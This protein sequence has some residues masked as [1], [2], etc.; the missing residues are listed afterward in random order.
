M[1]CVWVWI[2]PNNFHPK[3]RQ[4][5]FCL[6][7]IKF[8]ECCEQ[9]SGVGERRLQRGRGSVQGHSYMGNA[10][11]VFSFQESGWDSHVSNANDVSSFQ[12]SGWAMSATQMKCSV[13]KR[14]GGIAMSATQMKCS[15]FHVSKANEVFSFQESGW[16]SHVSSAND[17]SSFQE[18]GW[19]SH[20]SSANEVFSFQESGWDSH[21]SNANEVFSF[22]ES[23]WDSH[24]SNA[25]EVFSFQESGWDSHVSNANEVFSFQESGWDSH[26]SNANE[27]FSFQESGWDSHVSNMKLLFL[28]R[29][30]NH[31]ANKKEVYGV[32]GENFLMQTL[33]A[34][35]NAQTH[36]RYMNCQGVTISQR[37]VTQASNT[38]KASIS[39][40][41][42]YRSLNVK[43]EQIRKWLTFTNPPNPS[44]AKSCILHSSVWHT[45]M[46]TTLHPGFA[47]HHSSTGYATKGALL[48][49]VNPSLFL[50]TLP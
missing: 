49:S 46:F 12:E 9:R 2:V 50:Q 48:I 3:S 41:N 42:D 29:E 38:R 43:Q 5:V 45:H 14:V 31:V 47:I 30:G 11:E 40:Q 35:M 1:S 44:F 28:K 33:H 39:Q 32:V 25:N 34:S 6:P 37:Q 27:V 18:S 20:V 7:L 16:D 15:V 23:G 10:N 4:S 21:V 13:F 26:V 19:D 24:V 8:L 22:Q 36:L 17:V